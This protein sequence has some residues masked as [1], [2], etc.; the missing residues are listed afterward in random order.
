MLPSAHLGAA[1]GFPKSAP[2]TCYS[3]RRKGGAIQVVEKA[4]VHGLANVHNS[5]AFQGFLKWGEGFDC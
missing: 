1:L 3:E 5:C 4:A 2:N